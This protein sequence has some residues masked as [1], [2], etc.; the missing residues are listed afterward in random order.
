MLREHFLF[1]NASAKVRS[2]GNSAPSPSVPAPGLRINAETVR[3]AL[4]KISFVQRVG[5]NSRKC[6]H[7]YCEMVTHTHKSI[8]IC[9]D[10]TSC[11]TFF[12]LPSFLFLFF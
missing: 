5:F 10:L 8:I 6:T 2:S 4:P 12:F 1:A 3:V 9:L 7:A 11:V